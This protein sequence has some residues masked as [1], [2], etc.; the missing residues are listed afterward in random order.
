MVMLGTAGMALISVRNIVQFGLLAVPLLALH[1]S[2]P[3]NQGLGRRPFVQRFAV[4]A[5]TGVALPY[6]LAS[7][8]SL[9]GLALAQ[10]RVAGRQLVPEGFVAERFPVDAVTW[11]RNRKVQGR[12]FHEFIWG[13]YLL[14]AWPEMKVFIDG[15]SDFYG[16]EFIRAHRHV[17]NIQP[18]WRDSLAAWDIDLAL[19]ATGGPL[20]SELLLDDG[21]QPV[22]CDR[23]AV[24]LQRT[25][26]GLD[27]VP[28]TGC[29]AVSAES[30]AG[31]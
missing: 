7:L 23:T 21:W 6:I 19:V 8:V 29:A 31:R 14:Y 4:S 26:G 24:M 17:V 20:T 1:L 16:G 22:Y 28:H 2:Q 13:G 30:G 11:A 27:S 15:G 5:R 12:M 25:G 3:W 9:L 10:G 18:G